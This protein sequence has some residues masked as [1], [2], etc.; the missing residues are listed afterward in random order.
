[1][2]G[3]VGRVALVTGGGRGIGR[4]IV[5]HLLTAGWSVAVLEVDAI[6]AKQLEQPGEPKLAV[7]RGDV[8]R[9][10]DAEHAVQV[11]MERFGALHGLVNNAAIATPH[12]PDSGELDYSYWRR[13]MAVNLD[14]AFLC[15]RAAMDQLSAGRGAVV[16]IASTRALQSEAHSEAYAASKGGLIA[17][18]HALAVSLGPKVRVNAVSP[19]WID[20][21]DRRDD[22]AVPLSFEDHAQHPV[23]RVGR[24]EDVAHLVEYL[25]DS[26]RSGFITG[27]NFVVDGG[28]TK[29]MIYL[30]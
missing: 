17:L 16:N 21:V 29:K 20:T 13:V 30:E 14:G 23:G 12:P 19:G 18:T 3:R 6:A 9:E 1:M 4:A 5:G 10:G 15:V 27:Q 24:P 8:S 2:V 11:A 26:E 28:M 7:I 25:I 22:V